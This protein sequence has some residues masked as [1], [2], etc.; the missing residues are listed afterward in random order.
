MSSNFN[1]D[2]ESDQLIEKGDG[3]VMYTINVSKYLNPEYIALLDDIAR[4]VTIQIVIQLMIFL[5]SP[6][7]NSFFDIRFFEILLYVVLGVSA[8]WLVIKKL[9]KLV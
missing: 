6:S 3:S 9:V 1:K 2:S 5:S 7:T 8:Y 4:M